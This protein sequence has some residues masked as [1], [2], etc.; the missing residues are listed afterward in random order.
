LQARADFSDRYR[1]AEAEALHRMDAGRAQEELL[2]GRFHALRRNLHAETAAEADDCVDDRRQ[3]HPRAV[4]L[5]AAELI[6]WKA[7]IYS[8]I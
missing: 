4:A 7:Q 1:P 3:P 8:V 5:R 2:V 6:N